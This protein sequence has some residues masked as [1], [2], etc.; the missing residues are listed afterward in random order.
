[1]L[2][3]QEYSVRW[4][5]LVAKRGGSVVQ[6]RWHLMKQTISGSRNMELHQQVC[7]HSVSAHP[8]CATECAWS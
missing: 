7:A 8:L 4:G 1:M 2:S 3:L 6:R 5:E